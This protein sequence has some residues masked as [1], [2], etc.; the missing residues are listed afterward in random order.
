[1][2]FFTEDDCKLQDYLD[3]ETNTFSV[4]T[5]TANAFRDEGS[6][7]IPG[8]GQTT[9][10]LLTIQ[11]DDIPSGQPI[12]LEETG[13]FYYHMEADN[14]YLN[15]ASCSAD[16]YL[17][18]NVEQLNWFADRV[19]SG[20]NQINGKFYNNYT[21]L[22]FFA[23][24][25]SFPGIGTEEYPFL[26]IF[27]GSAATVELNMNTTG[28]NTGFFG[29]V[30]KGYTNWQYKSGQYPE[31][32]VIIQNLTLTGSVNST[33]SNTGA[34]AGKINGISVMYSITNN[35]TVTST[36]DNVGGIAGYMAKNDV[37]NYNSQGTINIFNNGNVSGGKNV[38]GIFGLAEDNMFTQF[39]TSNRMIYNTGEVRGIDNV[40]GLFG[41]ATDTLFSFGYNSRGIDD[42]TRFDLN[43]GSVTATNGAAG[44]VAGEIGQNV[45][46]YYATNIADISGK[47]A[48]GV[49]GKIT[50]D[51]NLVEK[52]WNRGNVSSPEGI[53]GGVVGEITAQTLTFRDTA[54]LG[55]V[56]GGTIGGIVGQVAEGLDFNDI[57]DN[58]YI[59]GT[60]VSDA[61]NGIMISEESLRYASNVY[62]Y[63]AAFSGEGDES[64]GDGS[65]ENPYRL[66]TPDDLVWFAAKVNHNTE[67]GTDNELCAELM[68]DIDLS[69]VSFVYFGGIGI[70]VTS[71]FQIESNT[72]YK[73]TFDGKGYTVTL[74]MV[75]K[76]ADV[77]AGF[78]HTVRG[79]TVRNLT[80]N[81][82]ISG[83]CRGGAIANVIGDL[84]G[85]TPSTIENCINE[86]T[87]IANSFITN[88]CINIG[89]IVG[90]MNLGSVITNCV[91]NGN[92]KGDRQVGGIVGSMNGISQFGVD[93]NG[94]PLLPTIIQ[95]CE[96]NGHVQGNESVGGIV[97]Y[98][99]G[100]V[101]PGMFILD[102]VNNGDV[103]Y[104]GKPYTGGGTSGQVDSAV[105]GILGMG[106]QSYL[107]IQ[108][109]TNN[110]H[111]FG[112]ANALG[113]IIGRL[114]S[115]GSINNSNSSA[116][117]N[118][119]INNGIVESTFNDPNAT[120][121]VLSITNYVKD[122]IYV[123]GIIGLT[124]DQNTADTTSDISGNT[125]NGQIIGNL[126]PS[127]QVGSITGVDTKNSHAVGQNTTTVLTERDKTDE[128]ITY[129]EPQITQPGNNNDKNN[130]VGEDYGD[131]GETRPAIGTTP[132]AVAAPE[133]LPNNPVSPA[134][135]NP[136][137]SAINTDIDDDYVP[138]TANPQSQQQE[139]PLNPSRN[140]RAR[141]TTPVEQQVPPVELR[142]LQAAERPTV[143][144]NTEAAQSNEQPPQ[145]EV[146]E[147]Q[148]PQ[149]D[150]DEVQIPQ[151]EGISIDASRISPTLIIIPLVAVIVIIG[152]IGIIR[153][154]NKQRA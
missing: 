143:L 6:V 80:I 148:P 154:R 116:I 118:D 68:N 109:N 11:A 139:T 100:E 104:T 108:R 147:G 137:H 53:A 33:G 63:I 55:S 52:A 141:Q 114:P 37:S 67:E 133:P 5:S 102:C 61:V 9:L 28:N 39:S 110:G 78:F 82:L 31:D 12:L 7:L 83:L 13:A 135:D 145:D 81:G 20:D 89:G 106:S 107:T 132:Q 22:P 92:V 91:N 151:M 98:A 131:D 35:A 144:E 19:N 119:C 105:G 124:G 126:A 47:T 27:S 149:E 65:L 54:S 66:S 90:S 120:Y 21:D 97:G 30:G 101:Y 41:K 125:N 23:T 64:R 127:G 111:V 77:A 88:T 58:F 60:A 34:L 26:G 153:F 57:G 86:A 140:N 17:I 117:V 24:D 36:G 16:F 112:P 4:N 45:T 14:G 146:N 49:I 136:V 38:G 56:T 1:M 73:G 150:I 85:R 129:V 25:E 113:G 130:A 10:N 93:Y 123:G 18:K 32:I 138:L 79:G 87:I 29:A 42:S 69:H 51:S 43:S 59:K 48:G 76:V 142:E 15:L 50:G 115:G 8:T 3:E 152:I 128:R 134:V 75:I 99:V 95:Y 62:S 44:G 72:A 70:V 2:F 121:S 71:G 84:N 40:G 122:G 103:E 94:M 46:L 96:N 74:N